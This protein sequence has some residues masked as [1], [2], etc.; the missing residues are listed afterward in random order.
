MTA[1]AG[2]NFVNAVVYLVTLPVAPFIV[3]SFCPD[4]AASDIGFRSGALEGCF[5]A[6]AFFGAAFWAWVADRYGRRP[7]LLWSLAGT[8]A[9]SVAF[10][11]ASSYGLALCIKLAW[12]FISGVSAL[13]HL[14]R[15]APQSC[16]HRIIRVIRR[17][18]RI[19]PS[20]PSTAELGVAKT[21]LSEISNDATGPRAFSYISVA[22]G[23]GRLVGPAIG[24]LLAQPALKYAD[25]FPSDGLFSRHPFLLPCLVCAVITAAVWLL[26]AM[27]LQETRP[28][29]S[30]SK[31]ATAAAAAAASTTAAP[32]S[33]HGGRLSA[34]G[35]G[36]AHGMPVHA[37]AESSTTLSSPSGRPQD[38]VGLLDHDGAAVAVDSSSLCV[39]VLANQQLTATPLTSTAVECSSRADPPSPCPAPVPAPAPPSASSTAATGWAT[40]SCDTRMSVPAR[41]AFKHAL[42]GQG[43]MD[44]VPGVLSDSVVA[45]DSAP[46][47][48][49]PAAATDSVGGAHA[50]DASASGYWPTLLR[51]LRDRAVASTVAIF[52]CMS[53]V[54]LVAT[55]LFPLYVV[56]GREAG[57]F[58]WTGEEVGLVVA[59]TGPVLLAWTLLAYD[60]LV[61]RIGLVRVARWSIGLNAL[62]M[63]VTPM[64]SLA[65]AARPPLTAEQQAAQVEAA[66]EAA[67]AAASG[68]GAAAAAAASTAAA[69]VSKTALEWVVLA[70]VFVASTLTRTTAYTCIFVFVSNS[71]LPRDRASANGIGQAAS[72]LARALGPPLGTSLFAWSVPSSNTA[73]GWPV[74]YHLSWYALAACTAAVLWL[75]YSMPPWIARKRESASSSR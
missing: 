68:D 2:V 13:S 53:A 5:H 74:D 69:A 40:S 59:L 30:I 58:S 42:A 38:D 20:R 24:G 52:A 54:G 50:A 43:S 34:E 8:A 37:V 41:P 48:L 6:G 47:K 26:G 55:E 1:L 14:L 21:A 67:A 31:L 25:V 33:H 71:A 12:G 44:S 16:S 18:R 17:F 19:P 63:A 28:V 9:L 15:K 11:L 65:L 27:Q 72:S 36:N 35:R 70:T 51:L 22:T 73:A 66:S 75:T 49:L 60:P 56:G 39:H 7:A 64:C 61:K 3:I 46:A 32:V 4:L 29:G 45:A 57:G 62:C 10:G 23:L